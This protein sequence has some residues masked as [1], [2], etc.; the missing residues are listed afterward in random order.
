MR[1]EMV[2]TQI[3]QSHTAPQSPVHMTNMKEDEI[4]HYA[5]LSLHTVCWRCVRHCATVSDEVCNICDCRNQVG[6]W[7]KYC[8]GLQCENVFK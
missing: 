1:Y 2:P 4:N 3:A 5:W 6:V 8:L 7:V